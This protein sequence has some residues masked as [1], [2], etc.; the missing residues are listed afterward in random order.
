[1]D[2]ANE[3]LTDLAAKRP[4]DPRI[5]MNSALIEYRKDGEI[6]KFRD[7]LTEIFV[8]IR[9]PSLT[10]LATNDDA[11]A[12]PKPFEEA[13]YAVLIY[14]CALAHVMRKDFGI[15][16]H[17]LKRVRTDTKFLSVKIVS[18]CSLLQP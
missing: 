2:D 5:M 16:E 9:G 7:R 18:K 12:N 15:A 3:I 13:L 8:K 11:V 17:L 14:N 4:L 1:M 6:K 10:V